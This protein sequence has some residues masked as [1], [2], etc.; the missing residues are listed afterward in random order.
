VVI[1]TA[2]TDVY[3][4]AEAMAAGAAGFV[5]KSQSP[6]E[7]SKALR[8]AAALPVNPATVAAARMST[9]VI[10][11]RKPVAAREEAMAS[12]SETEAQVVGDAIVVWVKRVLRT[13][14]GAGREANRRT[15]MNTLRVS[16]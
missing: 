8:A 13:F 3:K 4:E 15:R 5:L 9:R 2:F 16:N 7:F 14:G 11:N 6:G 12:E 1:M 10:S